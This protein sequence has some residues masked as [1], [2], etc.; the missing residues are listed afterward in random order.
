M[1]GAAAMSLSSFCVVTNALRLNLLDLDKGGLPAGAESTAPEPIPETAAPEADK[2]QENKGGVPMKTKTLK[3]E[4]MMCAHCQAHV[5]KALNALE[6][7]SATVD[8]EGGKAVCQVADTVT[9]EALKAAVT[10]AG[11]TV[12]GIEG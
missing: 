7:V 11:Y 4:G 9:D 5:D 10:E 3:I 8:L 12:T 6:G 2:T 1:I